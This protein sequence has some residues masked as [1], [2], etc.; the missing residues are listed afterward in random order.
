M[1]DVRITALPV[2]PNPITGD[3]LVPIV[4]DGQTVQTTVSAITQSPSLTQTFLTIGQQPQ[5]PNSRYIATGTGIGFTDGGAQNPYT[6]AL[7]GTSGSLEATSTGII[8]KTAPNT[9]ASR[10]LATSGNGISVS[11]GDG[12]SGNPTFQLTGV[13]QAIANASGLGLLALGAG[14]TISPVTITG[15]AN[16]ISV[17][18]GDGSVTPTIGLANNPVIPGTASVKIPIGTTSERSVGTDGEIRFNSQRNEY[19]AYANGVWRDFS[20]S[21]GVVT[22][23]AGL[24]GLTPDIPTSGAIT[25]G[26][27]LNSTSGGTGASALTGYLYSNGASAATASATIPT[28]DLSGTI[29]NAQ[30]A[31]SAVTVNGTSISLGGTG[32]ITAVNPNALTIGTGLSGTSYDGSAAATVAISNTSVVA[33]TYG[34]A[35]AVP[36]F[37]V[38]AQGQLTSVTNTTIAIPSTAITDKGLANGVA[39]LDGAG[40]VPTSQLPAAVLGAVSYQGTWNATTNT[41][42]LTS[43][44]GTKGYY[45]VVSTAGTTNLNGVTDWQIGD[46]AIYNGTAWEKIDNTDAVSSVNGFTGAVVLSASDVG[47]YP[48]TNPNGY[49]SNTG[50]VTSVGGTGTVNGITLTGTVTTSGSLTLGGTLSG[51]DLAT[52]V[53]GTLPIA[54][55][56]TGATTRQDAMDA[57]AGATTAGQYLRGDGTDVVM[58]AIQAADVPTLN[59]N[60]TGTAANVTGTV[61]VANGGTGQT[62]YTD[63][64][65]LIGNTTGNTLAKSTLTAGS[66]VSITNGAGSITISATGSG[67]TVTSVASGTGLTGGPITTTGTLSVATNGITDTL[68]RD[69]AA[70]S[71]IGRSANTSGDPADI[72]AASDHQVLRRSGTA[73]G[74]GAVALDQ[75][76]AVTGALAVANG[77]TG[78]TATPT[79]GQIDI[80]NGSGFTR[81]TLT[82]GSGISI[83]NGAGS[84]T[85]T[86]LAG[87]GTVTS[88]G[89][90]GT[91]NGITLTG[92][93]TTTGNL[94]LGGTLSGVSLS[95]QVTGTL[96]IANGGTGA[97]TR[98]DAMDALAGAVTSGQYLRGNGTDVVMSAIQAA[99]VPTLNQNT[100]G[101]ATNATNAT[102]AAITEDTATASAVYPAWVTANTGNLPLKVTSTKLSFV[103]STGALT[104]TGGISGGTF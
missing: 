4:Q 30:L 2:A 36:V 71:V 3:E 13:A 19:E 70:L 49:T 89:G 40:T 96:P 39:S 54:N 79:N 9:I 6:L 33:A 34:S 15:A 91:V 18:G 103:P 75:S 87:G 50:T 93:V 8:A 73:I 21:G 104:A 14:S 77:G 53:T 72:A 35:T 83:T 62:T 58:S 90:T 32:T 82:A 78:L 64:Q 41:P 100:T 56:G 59:Q 88:V 92:T 61:A 68:L 37:A 69:S 97:T 46:W 27:I 26:G 24:T 16:Q 7:N 31:N 42:T 65:L 51:V 5:L 17:L 84:V 74:F 81:S 66:G 67:G 10:T 23:N 57:L 76:N 95:T 28:T 12:V 44:V 86:S 20:L 25:L 11:D 94:T 98:Q 48:N 85:I 80:G 22:F 60:T 45:Y 38:N 102:N 43:S 52:Q 55:G 1:A 63:G 47:A 101:T 29:S 99:D